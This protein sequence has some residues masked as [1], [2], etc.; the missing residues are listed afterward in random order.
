MTADQPVTAAALEVFAL[1]L[2]LAQMNHH[3]DALRST[4]HDIAGS[5]PGFFWGVAALLSAAA[6]NHAVQARGGDRQAAARAAARAFWEGNGESI[7]CAPVAGD[8]WR[9]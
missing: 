2:T 1:R 3:L 8:A 5:G 6:A 7:E 9:L 4:M